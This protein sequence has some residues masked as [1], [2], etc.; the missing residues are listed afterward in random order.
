[1]SIL[2]FVNHRYAKTALKYGDG[3]LRRVKNILIGL[4]LGIFVTSIASNLLL[5]NSLFKSVYCNWEELEEIF[6]L[7]K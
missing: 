7:Q 3:N 6:Q 2:A 1:M 5:S 4:V